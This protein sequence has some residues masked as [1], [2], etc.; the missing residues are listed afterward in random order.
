LHLM[1]L[2]FHH[3]YELTKRGFDKAIETAN[4]LTKSS[5]GFKLAENEVNNWAYKLA[6]KGK[7]E[8]ALEI[9]KLNVT[10]YP[11]SYNTYDSLAEAYENT[12]NKELAIK[13]FKRSLALNPNNT[14][15]TEHLKHLE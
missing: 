3:P 12:G 15:G 11:D 4:E 10:L 6:G 9:F 14:N 1:G 8:Q 5:P 13:N 2:A 7:K